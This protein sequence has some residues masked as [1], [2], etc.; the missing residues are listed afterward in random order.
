MRVKCFLALEQKHLHIFEIIWNN[1]NS[2]Y[3]CFA[4]LS[5]WYRSKPTILSMIEIIYSTHVPR[6]MAYRIANHWAEQ[7]PND[8]F[9]LSEDKYTGSYFNEVGANLLQS[10]SLPLAIFRCLIC[11]RFL[12]WILLFQRFYSWSPNKLCVF[13]SLLLPVLDIDRPLRSDGS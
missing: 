4:Q 5:A 9:Y 13:F 1:L 11:F 3:N 6:D 8:L 12:Y 7:P 2:Y 10:L